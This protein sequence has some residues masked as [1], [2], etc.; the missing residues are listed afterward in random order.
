MWQTTPAFGR[1]TGPQE[2]D[3]ALWVKRCGVLACRAVYR[4]LLRPAW[5]LSSLLVAVLII[6][7]LSL[8]VWQL[9]RL[10]E[11]KDL[12]ATVEARSAEV[13][14]DVAEVVDPSQGPEVAADVEWRPVAAT[15]TFDADTQIRVVNRTVGGQP[16]QWYLSPM[17][18]ADGSVL[19]VNRGFV[20]RGVD[21][22]D[23]TPPQTGTVQ[24]TGL[25]RASQEEAGLGA[26][27]PEG[28][29]L[30]EIPRIDLT[31]LEAALGEAG[32]GPVYPMWLQLDPPLDDPLSVDPNTADSNV[33]TPQ[34]LPGPSL[35]NGP[36]LSYAGQWFL[37]S[38][39]AIFGYPLVV[40]RVA[41]SRAGVGSKADRR[42]AVPVDEPP[43]LPRH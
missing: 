4:F 27:A 13:V 33:V 10:D 42:A 18:L 1:R 35:D 40:R 26:Q 28:A 5:L 14:V 17:E 25:L 32:F 41:R 34:P 30:V 2:Y 6:V 15:G 22:G 38:L 20:G 43:P 21:P 11:R 8:G 19:V 12:N 24:V 29:E 23:V 16:G 3:P 31:R 7:L 39:I 37:F 9:R 36:H